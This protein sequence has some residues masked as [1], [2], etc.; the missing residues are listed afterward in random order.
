MT[1]DATNKS[2]DRSG[3]GAAIRLLYPRGYR[4]EATADK[5]DEL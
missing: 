4:S 1:D 5:A 2:I 3:R